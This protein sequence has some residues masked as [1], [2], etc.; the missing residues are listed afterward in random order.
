M[1]SANK[2]LLGKGLCDVGFSFF[3]YNFNGYF[4][5]SD[6]QTLLYMKLAKMDV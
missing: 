2:Q 1:N 3:C 4:F 6:T 5:L